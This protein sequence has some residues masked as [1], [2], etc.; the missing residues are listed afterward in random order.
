MDQTLK[1]N[2][3]IA[4]L[5]VN[6]STLIRQCSK[7]ANFYLSGGIINRASYSVRVLKTMIQTL[8]PDSQLPCYRKGRPGTSRMSA[9]NAWAFSR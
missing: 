5:A 2:A 8:L 1:R 3:P 6:G 4:V 7:L 9:S